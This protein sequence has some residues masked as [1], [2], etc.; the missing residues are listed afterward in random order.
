MVSTLA[1]NATDVGLIPALG[2]ISPI[3]I[4]PM[5]LVAVTSILSKLRTVWLLN[6][7]CINVIVSI[8][9]LTVPGG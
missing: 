6:L 2:T 1:W 7:P 8:K 5:I 4:T 9:R 3:F